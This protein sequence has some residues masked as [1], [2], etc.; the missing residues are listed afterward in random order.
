MALIPTRTA[1]AAVVAHLAGELTPVTVRLSVGTSPPATP[2]VIVH[3]VAGTPVGPLGD[4]DAQLR[5]A[6]Q[7]TCVGATAEQA[8]WCHDQ[9]AAALLRATITTGDGD[10]AS[11]PIWPIPGS[12]QPVMRDDDL[13]TPL[14]Y[15]TCGWMA[16]LQPAPD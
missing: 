12:Q 4:P 9:A 5:V 6:F 1:A 14:Y 2:S 13:A 10:A 7:T 8:L 11:L 3:P 16:H 15:V